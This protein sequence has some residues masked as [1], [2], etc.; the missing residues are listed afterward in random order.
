MWISK[1]FHLKRGIKLE[2]KLLLGK[3]VAHHTVL[4]LNKTIHDLHKLNIVPKLAAILIGENPAS[5]IY[6]NNKAKFFS[7]N[8]CDSQTFEFDSNISESEVLELICDNS[9]ALDLLRWKPEVTLNKGLEK[10]I[11][12][13]SQN[14][15]LFKKNHYT[16]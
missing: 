7:K 15:N 16:I 14:I 13:I 3:E 11:N 6:V 12:F 4:K 9:K 8:N 5:Q 2:N 10:T 1:F